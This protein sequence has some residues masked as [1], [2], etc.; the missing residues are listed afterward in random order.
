MKYGLT[1]TRFAEVEKE[2]IHT[3]L[4]LVA[5]AQEIR[6]TTAPGFRFNHLWS[7]VDNAIN[8]TR[9]LRTAL[10]NEVVSQN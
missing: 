2:L 1:S 4:Y 8:Y 7:Q 3:E 5:L 9:T 10:K 6:E